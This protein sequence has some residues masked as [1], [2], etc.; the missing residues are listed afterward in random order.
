MEDKKE[1]EW[2]A[3]ERLGEVPFTPPLQKQECEHEWNKPGIDTESDITCYAFKCKKCPAMEVKMISHPQDSAKGWELLEGA[4]EIQIVNLVRRNH[5]AQEC[6]HQGNCLNE[7]EM[8]PMLTHILKEQESAY[9]QRLVE[10]MSKN[11]YY[12]SSPNKEV[13]KFEEGFVEA[14]N[15]I[16]TLLED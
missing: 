10:Q 2:E 7:Y 8:F 11:K 4:P 9:K 14:H 1:Q 5:S 3:R 12:Y 13:T 15:Q 16:L 6:K